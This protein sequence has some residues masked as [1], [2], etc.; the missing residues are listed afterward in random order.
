[1][2]LFNLLLEMLNKTEQYKNSEGLNGSSEFLLTFWGAFTASE[3]I[4]FYY[5]KVNY[6]T[7][8]V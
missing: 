8:N 2:W 5:E 1:M 4:L 7:K 3:P 6:Q